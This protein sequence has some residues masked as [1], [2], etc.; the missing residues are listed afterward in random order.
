VR[1]RDVLRHPRVR[2]IAP[3]IGQGE[4]DIKEREREQVLTSGRVFA[5]G[6]NFHGELGLGDRLERT[7]LTE[8][9]R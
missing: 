5:C 3:E 2:T 7:V 6:H 9:E 8:I 4:T 1:S